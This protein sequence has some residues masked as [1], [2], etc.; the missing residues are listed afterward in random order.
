MKRR[1]AMIWRRRKRSSPAGRYT[2]YRGRVDGRALFFRCR[3]PV[4]RTVYV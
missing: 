2:G 3:E 4:E 1:A